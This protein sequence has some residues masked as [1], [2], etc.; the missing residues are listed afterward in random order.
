MP[1]ASGAMHHVRGAGLAILHRARQPVFGAWAVV[2]RVAAA[3]MG[4][5][6]WVVLAALVIVEWATVGVFAAIGTHNGV[7]Y[8]NGGDDTWY[9][10]SAWVLAHGHIPNGS[11]GYGYAFLLAPLARLGGPNLL[12]GLPY[13]IGLNILILWPIA[14]CC[15]YGLMKMIAGRGYA[16]LASLVWTVLPV[17]AI[18][19]FYQRYH[20]RYINVALAPSVGLTALADFPAMVC[21]L[22]AGYFALSA[23]TRRQSP[24]AIFAG[25]AAGLAIA[26]KPSNAIFLPAPFAALLVARYRRGLLEFA[27]GLV[28]ALIALALWKY[29]GLGY[30]PLLEKPSDVFAL[31]AL[32]TVPIA[33]LDV[34][35]YLPLNWGHLQDNINYIREFA[36][37]LRLLTWIIVAGAIGL[38]RRSG[39]GA[40]LIVVWLVSYVLLKGSSPVVTVKSGSFFRYLAPA[41]PAFFLLGASIP[42]LVPKWGPRVAATGRAA[43]PWPATSTS[44]KPLIRIAVV[45]SALPILALIVFRPLTKPDAAL[46][47]DFDQYVPANTFAL[48]ST[49]G[50]DGSVSL[51]W[52]GQRAGA[53]RVSYLVFRT[54]TNVTPPDGLTCTPHAH[55]ASTCAFYS[56]T[57]NRLIVPTAKTAATSW[58]DKP[59]AGTWNYRVALRAS[60]SHQ[61]ATGDFV[62]FSRAVTVTVP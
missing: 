56:D 26:V 53:A 34:H 60:E 13:V 54:P 57:N 24:D 47:T 35:R 49:V 9:Y 39:A 55:A 1:T 52:P 19:F 28:P 18:P 4:L 30:L 3:V 46:V 8:Y 31:G 5:P 12:G 38:A 45:I 6:V 48:S 40:I 10:T 32:P 27:L 50:G 59:P 51:N 33:G 22:V 14:V 7:V 58:L 37:S 62:M 41:F 42:L 23:V 17:A 11:A 43:A 25:L 29:R 20:H 15:I 21:L 2:S 44:W 16:Y 36:W 61:R